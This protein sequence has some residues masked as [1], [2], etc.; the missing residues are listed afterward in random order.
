MVNDPR[1]PKLGSSEPD[2]ALDLLR[3]LARSRESDPARP[4]RGRASP[5]PDHGGEKL[6]ALRVLAAKLHRQL[7]STEPE[8]GPRSPLRAP[9]RGA[10]LGG[11]QIAIAVAAVAALA[12]V[13]LG[14]VVWGL[15]SRE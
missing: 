9:R 10:A 14:F 12:L 5:E 6:D 4:D 8:A 3:A 11:R 2:D 1:P 13:G 15:K 7:K